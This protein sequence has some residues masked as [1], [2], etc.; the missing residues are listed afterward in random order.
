MT[1]FGTG[2]IRSNGAANTAIRVGGVSTNSGYTA[3]TGSIYRLTVTDGTTT[4]IDVDFTQGATGQT[5]FPAAKGGSW[6][7]YGTGVSDI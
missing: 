7:I 5:N 2:G 3:G 4:L 1:T 6:T